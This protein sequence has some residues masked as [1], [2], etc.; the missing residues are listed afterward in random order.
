[1][2][3]TPDNLLFFHLHFLLFRA[4][5]FS[6]STYWCQ[7]RAGHGALSRGVY[8]LPHCRKGNLT[9]PLHLWNNWRFLHA[10]LGN[11]AAGAAL[12]SSFLEISL[13]W[14]WSN[15][16]AFQT[17]CLC[18][19]LSPYFKERMAVMN[20]KEKRV[21]ACIFTKLQP[22]GSFSETESLECQ[23][24]LHWASGK[25]LPAHG[26]VGPEQSPPV[27]PHCPGPWERARWHHHPPLLLQ[28]SLGQ[29]RAEFMGAASYFSFGFPLQGG[30][31]DSL[32]TGDLPWSPSRSLCSTPW[33]GPSCP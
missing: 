20:K 13:S 26:K 4:P 2:L 15:G 7:H 18:K 11:N 21:K 6:N 24:W 12:A 33:A 3:T 22:R 30:C 32:A 17:T 1:M 14:L 27:P 9:M 25:G 5:A 31:G 19:R 16:T 10:R 8:H 28:A 23:E 29:G